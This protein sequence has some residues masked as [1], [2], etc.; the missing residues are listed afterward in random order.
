MAARIRGSGTEGSEEPT[1][2]EAMLLA[3]VEGATR[4]IDWEIGATRGDE[5]EAREEGTASA[6]RSSTEGD[7][8]VLYPARTAA[9][10]VYEL[11]E[12]H[13]NAFPEVVYL[14]L[15]R[16]AKEMH[17]WQFK[18]QWNPMGHLVIEESEPSRS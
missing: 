12:K 14:D 15:M 8:L 2:A 5:E 6:L 11:A 13:A 9:E 1:E 10:Q 18:M 16:V 7:T 3:H 4:E 17:D